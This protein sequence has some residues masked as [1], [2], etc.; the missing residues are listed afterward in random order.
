MTWVQ[1]VVAGFVNA[2]DR[3]EGRRTQDHSAM[4]SLVS[5]PRPD[6]LSTPLHDGLSISVHP[7]THRITI[8]GRGFWSLNYLEAHLR[9]F[10]ALLQDL[11]PA[12]TPLRT[13]VGLRDASVQ[14]SG[15][16]NRMHAAIGRLYRPPERTAV[17]VTRTLVR[18]QMQ[19]LFDPR[20]HGVFRSLENA[21]TWLED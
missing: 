1:I 3:T 10:E 2:V 16:A 15:V 6:Q 14:P 13:L 12:S 11:R 7:T 9:E 4:P 21:E 5:W 19:R 18:M 8:I 20:T 17:F